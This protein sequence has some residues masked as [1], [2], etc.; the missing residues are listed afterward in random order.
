MAIFNRRKALK[1]VLW[2]SDLVG[3]RLTLA[4]AEFFWALMLFWPGNT[5]DR[6]TYSHM[7]VIMVEEWWGMLFLVSSFI[8]V[9]IVLR[10][11]C[12]S[13]LA[14]YFAGWNF[15]LWGFT[16]WSMLASVYPPPAAIG[17]EIALALSAFWIWLR[18]ILQCEVDRH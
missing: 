4:C 1:R 8:Q 16:V 9:A 7:S 17:G 13:T 5:F 14:W 12:N 15:C 3:S 18:P 2:N 11:R 6:P 10:Q